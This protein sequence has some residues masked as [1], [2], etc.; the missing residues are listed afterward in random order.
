M[1]PKIA[2]PVQS[3]KWPLRLAGGFVVLIAVE[4]QPFWPAASAWALT[5]VEYVTSLLVLC[6][7]ALS[8]KGR[9][10]SSDG[11]WRFANVD[12]T[13]ILGNMN[14][15]IEGNPYGVTTR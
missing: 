13:P 14:V 8:G 2:T 12:G 4:A 10:R 11:P 7:L 15:D 3:L 5:A 9:K 1:K 6:L